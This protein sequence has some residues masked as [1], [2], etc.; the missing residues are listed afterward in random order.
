MQSGDPLDY[1]FADYTGLEVFYIDYTNAYSKENYKLWVDLLK[2]GK[3][4]WATA[5]CDEHALPTAKT[6]NVVYSE[7]KDAATYL[8]HI[9]QGDLTC[10]NVGVRMA[11]GDATM[12]GHTDF[13]GKRVVISIGDFHSTIAEDKRQF[14]VQIV[15]GDGVTYKREIDPTTT[16]YFAFDANESSSYYRVE[17]YCGSTLVALGNPIWND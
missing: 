4:V 13:N 7:K 11:I 1:W 3:R 12:G 10:G 14:T 16:N 5:G 8:S 9:S 6:L 15:G 2:R 17:V